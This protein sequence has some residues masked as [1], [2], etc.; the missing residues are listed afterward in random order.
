M[1]EHENGAL[2]ARR[3][4]MQLRLV[5]TLSL[6]LLPRATTQPAVVS[7]GR[8]VSATVGASDIES[9]Q[10]LPRAELVKLIKRLRKG[11]SGGETGGTAGISRGGGKAGGRGGGRGGGGGGGGRS[12]GRARLSRL[13]AAAATASTQQLLRTGALQ[14][15]RKS[16]CAAVVSGENSSICVPIPGSAPKCGLIGTRE[17]CERSLAPRAGPRYPASVPGAAVRAA[18]RSVC[19]WLGGQCVSAGE[20]DCAEPPPLFGGAAGGVTGGAAGATG[21]HAVDY[22]SEERAF[23]HACGGAA[24]TR[25]G[26]AGA[27]AQCPGLRGALARYARA[28]EAATREA[29]PI[30][31]VRAA[32]LLVIRDHWKNV[33]MGFMPAHVAATVLWA[34]GVGM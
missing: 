8:G 15:V 19:A 14:P 23:A 17:A 1:R 20:V 16:C 32:R 29:A 34:M 7:T 11:L 13:A 3:A 22:Y 30:E 6:L 4:C 5:A 18:E 21:A 25:R 33:G 27:G 2:L 28:H 26:A 10:S 31:G 9:L 12:G 24:P